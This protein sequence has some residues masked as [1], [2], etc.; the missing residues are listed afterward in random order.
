M[1]SLST[2]ARKIMGLPEP[3]GG[4]KGL[5]AGLPQQQK[6]KK[7]AKKAAHPVNP[8]EA[9]GAELAARTQLPPAPAAPVTSEAPA[10]PWVPQDESSGVVFARRFGRGLLWAVVA[11]AAITGVRAWVVPPTA[12]TAAPPTMTTAPTYPTADAQ[13]VAAR[14]SRAYLGWDE[15]KKEERVALLSAVLAA[16][17]EATMG[18]D[19]KGHQEVLAVQPGAVTPRDAG[20]AVARVDVLIRAVQPADPK[21]NPAAPPQLP[22]RWVGLDVPVVATGGRVVVTGPPGLV[23]IPATGPK[24]ADVPAVATDGAL[25]AQTKD[26]VAK[27]FTAYAG[28]DPESVS[29]PGAHLPPLAQGIELKGVA[30]WT[31]DAGD[32]ADRTGTARVLW[33]LG[34]AQVEMSYRVV[35]TRV[36]SSDAHRWQVSGLRGGTL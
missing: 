3:E 29:A 9:A 20:R 33:A 27:F 5:T 28:G 18:W 36:S 25:A 10:A 7:K 34:G 14:F 21:A 26:V 13:A 31:V 12:P 15:T 24:V 35:L 30:S 22:A 16:G 2:I 11:L 23:G 17:V 6:T 32:G 19:G 1:S 8:W 4:G